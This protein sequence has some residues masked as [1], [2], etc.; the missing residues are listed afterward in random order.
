MS[1]LLRACCISLGQEMYLECQGR[2][3]PTT[4]VCVLACE[5]CVK[6]A[7]VYWVTGQNVVS[8]SAVNEKWNDW[9]QQ[10]LLHFYQTTPDVVTNIDNHAGHCCVVTKLGTETGNHPQHRQG[11]WLTPQGHT[12]SSKNG[13]GSASETAGAD[14]SAKNRSCHKSLWSGRRCGKPTSG[15]QQSNATRTAG[16]KTARK[17]TNYSSRPK[18]P[19]PARAMLNRVVPPHAL[20][21]C[22]SAGCSRGV[23]PTDFDDKRALCCRAGMY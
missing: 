2:L 5:Y 8:C 22:I 7:E 4:H 13:A 18:R 10:V 11:Y 12:T 6:C 14:K 21:A 23:S 9:G 16:G 17:S 19:A 1:L 3:A 20:S 15:Q